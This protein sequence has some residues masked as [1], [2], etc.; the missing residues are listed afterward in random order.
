[1]IIVV[2]PAKSLDYD[3]PLATR[4]F[5]Q[6]EFLK[7][8]EQLVE[9]LK[10]LSPEDLSELMDISESL[11][12]L[13]FQR[14]ANWQPE[15]NLRNARQ[16]L[17][18]FKGD[19]YLGLKAEEFSVADVNFA[20]KHFRML[21]GLYGILRPLDL[22]QA[23]RLEMGTSFE[24][25]KGKNLYEFWGMKITNKLNELLS[26][27]KQQVLINL[28]SNE[29]FSA[30]KAKNI[31]GRIISPVFKDY[32]NGEYKIISFFA[33][34]ARGTMSSWLIR[35]RIKSPRKISSF[36]EDGYIFNE[37]L[38]TPDQPVFLRRDD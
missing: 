25:A 32:S 10:S 18:A 27:Q 2:S 35:N 7:D 28:A 21:S 26:E 24:N 22:M 17:Y 15:F 30:V 5:T 9:R 34:K 31:N 38:S 23:Y 11:G 8:S 14:F 1:M 12:E 33:K 16:A 29:Y 20:Q 36:A 3:S 37:E 13:N 19:V 4:R 6:P